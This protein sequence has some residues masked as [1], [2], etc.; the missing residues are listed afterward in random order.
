MLINENIAPNVHIQQ[1]LIF[2]GAYQESKSVAGAT[3][4]DET[5][6]RKLLNFC[7]P[8]S[9][10]VTRTL[11]NDLQLHFRVYSTKMRAFVHVQM[12]RAAV[13]IIVTH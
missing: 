8:T 3:D 11:P 9:I 4:S 1:Q 5:G 10:N 7:S 13:S 6:I 12:L 2:L